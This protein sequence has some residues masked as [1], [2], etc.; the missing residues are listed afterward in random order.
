MSKHFGPSEIQP[1]PWEPREE[2]CQLVQTFLED[3]SV[4]LPTP[5]ETFVECGLCGQVDS[6]D[7]DCPVLSLAAWLEMRDIPVTKEKK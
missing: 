4:T 5:D 2:T 1:D 3:V 7:D 6:H